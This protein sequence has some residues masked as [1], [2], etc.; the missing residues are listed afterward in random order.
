MASQL[1]TYPNVALAI[2]TEKA[3]RSSRTDVAI[4]RVLEELAKVAFASISDAVEWGPD[5]V[6]VVASEDMS[7][8]VAAAISEVS[9]TQ[10]RGGSTVKVKMHVTSWPLCTP[11]AAIWACSQIR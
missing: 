6:T 10:H 2:Q 9:Q 1:L 11:W 8:D 5:G 7:E 3:E 4:D